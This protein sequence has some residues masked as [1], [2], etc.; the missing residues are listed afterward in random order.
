[1]QVFKT[2]YATFMYHYSLALKSNENA[3]KSCTPVEET[4]NRG[5]FYITRDGLSGF[6]V[7]DGE[8]KYL[9]NEEKGRGKELVKTA[10][11]K[12]ARLLDC[13]DGFL[14]EFYRSL[15]FY[16]YARTPNWTKGEPDVVF[17]SLPKDMTGWAE[18][19]TANKQALWGA[20]V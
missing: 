13:F 5:E 20:D 14:V 18:R 4:E 16:A 11:S 17:M 8:L 19:T 6:C 15:G 3:K 9:F 7:C 1:M 10:I 12:G 2:S